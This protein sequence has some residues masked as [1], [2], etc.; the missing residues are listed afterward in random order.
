MKAPSRAEQ[1]KNETKLSI[2][3]GVQA[4]VAKNGGY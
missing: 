3:D 2:V 4:V 1:K